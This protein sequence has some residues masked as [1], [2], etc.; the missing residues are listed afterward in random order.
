MPPAN[1]FGGAAQLAV[2]NRVP[3]VAV[4]RWFQIA[5]DYL[6]W[7]QSFPYQL[8]VLRQR[9]D[10]SWSQEDDWQFTLPISPRSLQIATI[11]PSELNVNQDGV[12]EVVSPVRLRQWQLSGTMGVLPL[13]PAAPMQP[14][15]PSAAIFA[16]VVS[17][18]AASTTL[19]VIRNIYAGGLPSFVLTDQELDGTDVGR[20]SGYAQWDLLEKFFLR[21]YEAKSAD[22]GLQLALAVWKT[23]QV[24]L[25]KMSTFVLNRNL[26]DV[27]GWPYTLGGETWSSVQ[28]D[29]SPTA[30]EKAPGL[31][32]S[33]DRLAAAM[34]SVREAR[35]ILSHTSDIIDTAVGD[36]FSL[37]TEPMRETSLLLSDLAGATASL[38]DLPESIIQSCS[39]AVI[40]MISARDASAGVSSEVLDRLAALGS[41]VDD[42]RRLGALLGRS[43]TRV[44][45]SASS[46]ELVSD[47]AYDVFSNPSAHTAFLAGIRPGDLRLRPSIIDSIAR[48]RRRIKGLTRRD[49]RN[50][51]RNLRMAS[52]RLAASLGLSSETYQSRTQS[53]PGEVRAPNDAD[54]ATLFA[55]D[56]AAS[57]LDSV[58]V[59]MADTVS[60]TEKA[61]NYVAGLASAAGIPF[62]VPRSKLQVP[63]PYG[64][65]L[66]QVAER[67]RLDP[68]RAQELATM[69]GLIA[70]Y[71]DEVGTYHE[72]G[73]RPS[74]DTV[75]LD[76][77][78][79]IVVGQKMW[80]SSMVLPEVELQVLWVRRI[81]AAI[82][83]QVDQDVATYLPEDEA[84]VHTYL[85]NTLRGGLAMWIPSDAEP[86]PEGFDVDDPAVVAAP[87]AEMRTIGAD[88][89]L[90]ETG[91]LIITP[92]GDCRWA[93]GLALV[94]Q[95]V[96]DVV[97]TVR[98]SKLRHPTYGLP[99]VV[100][101]SAADMSPRE[102]AAAVRTAFAEDPLFSGVEAISVDQSGPRVR[103]GVSVGVKGVGRALPLA[104]ELR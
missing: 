96:R 1:R 57:V 2:Q 4:P 50:R 100:G 10:G 73:A 76:A 61:M 92:D 22:P 15:V 36:T 12:V 54:Y 75:T 66:E 87:D 79:R 23:Q 94:T 85:P 49:I 81:G 56:R 5:P 29:G 47:P 21:Y 101:Q 104:V 83:V 41:E 58:V 53:S 82:L 52:D 77:R 67:Y 14:F 20:C 72:L 25:V 90:D 99:E 103:M 37:V 80:L 16:G 28:I 64:C 65:T 3:D 32:G 35:G 39:A 74:G 18:R 93:R 98:G 46:G 43:D 91:D 30:F 17:S 88:L 33:P 102:L 97:G 60:A 11:M 51:A 55:L 6:R 8:L 42:L 63:F 78:I 19:D 34:D 70:P 84:R 40:S 71:V 24:Y 31:I 27:H 89:L 44:A 86:A 59:G 68:D 62:E 48:E 45:T 38:A 13:R 26:P 9:Q 7:D 95:V 69:N